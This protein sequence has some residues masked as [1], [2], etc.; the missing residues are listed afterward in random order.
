[1]PNQCPGRT[2]LHLAFHIS[3]VDGLAGI[4]HGSVAQN[5]YASGLRV[6][7]HVNEVDGEGR[8]YTLDLQPRWPSRVHARWVQLH[9]LKPSFWPPTVKMPPSN[10]T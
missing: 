6:D 4:L 5:F 8:P 2:P 10:R 3:R 7:F 9:S 1:M